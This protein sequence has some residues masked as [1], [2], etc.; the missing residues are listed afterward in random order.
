MHEERPKSHRSNYDT[1]GFNSQ[2]LFLLIC[3]HIFYMGYIHSLF[4]FDKNQ[5]QA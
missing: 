2:I 4:L 5:T 1:I 3:A